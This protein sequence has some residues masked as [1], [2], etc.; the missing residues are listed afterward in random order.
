[1]NAKERVEWV[2]RSQTKQELAERY[3]Q[4][5]K[6]YE[7]DLIN[8]GRVVGKEPAVELLLKYLPKEA[9][10]LDAGA[11]TGTIGELLH[12]LGYHNLVAI[13]LSEGMLA[14]ARQ[15]NIYRELHQMVLGDPLDFPTAS[16]DAVISV[17]VFTLAH[18]PASSFDELI[19]ITKS[20]GYIVFT[21]RPDFY[22][23]SDFKNKLSALE[24]D[25]QWA[26]VEVG[27][28]YQA[29]PQGDPDIYLQAWVYNVN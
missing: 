17:G 21:I 18:A 7:Q 10:I 25:G 9:R 11:G 16:F 20:G 27:E 15:K 1:M 26:L 23:T 4:W 6:E 8:Q 28:K 14:E 24:A 29:H 12:Q 2:Y 5:A 13:D 22:E 19:R 3:D